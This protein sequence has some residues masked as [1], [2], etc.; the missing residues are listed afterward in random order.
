M[1][2]QKKYNEAEV[3]EKAM[4]LFW[5]NGYLNTSA[6][7]LEREMGINLFSIYA[8]FKNKDGVLLEGI[9]LYKQYVKQQLLTP[10][11]QGEATL[12]NL[13]QYFY[14]YLQHI[15]EGEQYKGCLL[16]NTANELGQQMKPQIAQEIIL[17]SEELKNTFFT[18]LAQDGSKNT[19][20]I[21]RQA[22]Y[23]LVALQGI[24]LASKML[25][26]V[27]VDNYIEMT[28]KAIE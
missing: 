11:Q 22:D 16:I 19:Q 5:K 8:H 12:N 1:P 13:K 17:F 10:L 20:L 3:T 15:S 23:L 4:H 18:I 28:F 7:M 26:K 2:R 21:E 6:R 9:K 14:D 24:A 27:Q 25:Q